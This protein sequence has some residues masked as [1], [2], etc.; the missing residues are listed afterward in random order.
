MKGFNPSVILSM[1]HETN[2]SPTKN[3]FSIVSESFKQQKHVRH[4][5]HEVVFS[6]RTVSV[7]TCQCAMTLHPGESECFTKLQTPKTMGN[8]HIGFLVGFTPSTTSCD[9]SV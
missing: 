9:I 7:M 8:L 3:Q 1:A 4:C 5:A 6:I 2:I